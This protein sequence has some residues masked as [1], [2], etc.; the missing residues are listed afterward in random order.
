MI[1]DEVLLADSD[2][3]KAVIGS[4]LLKPQAIDECG[5][6]CGADFG[7]AELGDAFDALRRIDQVGFLRKWSTGQTILG[8]AQAG[9]P[10]S[11]AN[12]EYARKMM[13]A[14]GSGGLCS[15]HGGI[16]L[17]FARMRRLRSLLLNGIDKLG[18]RHSDP[19]EVA[20]RLEAELGLL[21]ARG[22]TAVRSFE[23]I[24]AEVIESLRRR[25]DAPT[26]TG[27][28]LGITRVDQA[29]GGMHGG[30]LVVLA[31]RT[32]QGKTALAMQA[33]LHNAVRG[34]RVLFVSLE[35]RDAELVTRVLCGESGVNGRRLRAGTFDDADIGD[36][37]AARQQ[38]GPVPV[39]VYDPPSATVE[40][41]NAVARLEHARGP[42]AL[43]VVDY[44]QL[45]RP[46]DLRQKRHEQVGHFSA[47]LKALAKEINAPVLALAQLN[48]EADGDAPRLAHLRESGSIE[49]DADAVLAIA[50]GGDD[51][52]TLYVLKHRHGET[53]EIPL[54]WIGA[55]TRF[56]EPAEED[57]FTDWNRGH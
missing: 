47:S 35:M 40:R 1:G 27:A 36:L 45:L 3:E 25:L 32:G 53:G 24:A 39:S 18:E 31:A 4:I 15:Y 33:A 9:A 10:P 29:V 49:Q 37:D 54:R 50:K 20:Q 5:D 48:R 2:A 46:A 19:L 43:V 26:K 41:V 22:A 12:A 55:E 44:L 34:G 14:A 23:T 51:E 56:V 38:L 52:A 8:M 57:H 6:L 16:V 7:D 28:G 17:R 30:E 21:G 13:D 11:V 42:L